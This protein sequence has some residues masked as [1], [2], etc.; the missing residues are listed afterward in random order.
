M[1]S[2]LVINT[3]ILTLVQSLGDHHERDFVQ[4]GLVRP[5]MYARKRRDAP[6]EAI[7]VGD[8]TLVLNPESNLVVGP[9]LAAEWISRNGDVTLTALH[10]CDYKLGVVSGLERESR[11]AV[12]VC[13]RCITGYINV[14]GTPF[15]LQPSNASDGTH[16]LLR[17]V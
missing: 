15:F 14:G 2:S 5:K 16:Q 9:S 6:E 4:V 3:V 13:G 7:E 12:A 11:V 1:L 10:Q 17:C 8:W